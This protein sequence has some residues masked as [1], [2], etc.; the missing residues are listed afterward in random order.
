MQSLVEQA[1]DLAKAAHEGQRRKYTGEPYW[2]H[3]RNVAELVAE[4]TDDEEMIAAAWLHDT[5]ED[6]AVDYSTIRSGFGQ[7]VAQ[8]VL[9]LTDEYTHEKYP[10]MNRASRKKAEAER[11]SK[12]SADARTIKLA[13]IKDNTRDIVERD[14][15]FAKIYLAEKRDILA[16][17][18]LPEDAV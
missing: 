11:L 2:H 6:T 13:D 3:L 1:A 5:L 12:I 7:R 16:G 4:V 14:P 18:G 17:W 8:L 9:E 15:G 10:G